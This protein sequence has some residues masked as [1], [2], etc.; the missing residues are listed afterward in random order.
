ML[1]PYCGTAFPEPCLNRHGFWG[2]TITVHQPSRFALYLLDD[3]QREHKGKVVRLDLAVDLYPDQVFACWEWLLYRL[4][5]KYRQ[6]GPMFIECENTLG[7]VDHRGRKAPT[8]NIEL[9][10]DKP[11]KLNGLPCVHPEI[12]LTRARTILIMSGTS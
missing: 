3:H 8:R 5:L 2:W 9:Y 11:S 4:I 10:L 6:G 1:K 7:W 12:K